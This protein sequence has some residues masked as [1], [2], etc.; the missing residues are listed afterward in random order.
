MIILDD[1][2]TGIQ[3]VHGL[4]VYMSWD[5]T[6]FEEIFANSETAFIHT[7][8]RAYPPGKA[9]IILDE[10]LTN[11]LEVSKTYNSGFE[12]ISRSDSTLRG[13]YPLETEHIRN[14]IEAE[15]GEKIDGEILIPFFKEGGRLTAN[16]IHY[17]EDNE[18]LVPAYLTE[19]AKDP[20]FGFS[21]SD[22]KEYIE[23]KT[24]GKYKA[25]EVS[26]VSL[27]MLRNNQK[28]EIINILLKAKDFS[29]IIINAVEYNDLKAFIPSLIEARQRGKKY[30]FRTA[31][32]FV[33][34]YSFNEDKDLLDKKELETYTK[35][36][37]NILLIAGSYTRKTSSQL[38]ILK[39]SHKIEP[40]ELKVSNLLEGKTS[41]EKEVEE[42]T[43]KI[44]F[45][46]KSGKNPVL[47]TSRKLVKT[48]DHL[49]TA[50]I[51]SSALIQVVSRLNERPRIVIAKGGITS[52]VIAVTGLKIWKAIVEGQVLPGVPMIKCGENSKWPQM[53]YIIFPGNVGTEN[54]LKELYD[55]LV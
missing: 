41:F 30:I 14:K 13:H 45:L 53:P 36:N 3:T 21:T 27:N 37:K 10:I 22:L 2:P 46:M 25:S 24:D 44:D 15:T 38:R 6:A 42:S 48:G 49:R 43:K 1:D 51:I 50:G 32:S 52:S 8:T 19:F 40:V 28:N 34:N 5:K 11:I 12:I 26:S 55:K 16:D 17:V 29:K 33:K 54:S 39:E 23:E 7:N 31:A 9:T 35:G 18:M 4:N 20:D 47:F